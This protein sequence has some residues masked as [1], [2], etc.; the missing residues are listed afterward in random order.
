MKKAI[1]FGVLAGIAG[2][3]SNAAN[4]AELVYDIDFETPTYTAPGVTSSIAN[5]A[6]ESATAGPWNAAGWSIVYGVNRTTGNPAG[7]TLITLS[8]LAANSAVSI[9]S[10]V[11]GFLESWDSYNGGCCNPDYLDVFINGALVATMTADNAFPGSIEDYDGATELFDGVQANA[12]GYYSDTLVDLSTAAFAN[13][14]ADGSGTWTLGIRARGGGWQGG[15]DEGWGF[16]NLAIYGD[17]VRT[18]AVPEPA[19]WAMMILGF[20][21]IGGMMRG[22]SRRRTALTA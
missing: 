10:G 13:S 19:T 7:Q 5:F 12:N 18:G 9:G 14:F 16:D 22:S 2:L 21:A 15:S 20:G 6:I 8:G 17:V 3:S 4:A 11:L 1:L